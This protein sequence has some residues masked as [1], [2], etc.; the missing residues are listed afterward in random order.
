MSLWG[1]DSDRKRFATLSTTFSNTYQ[2]SSN[3]TTRSPPPLP[4][5]PPID[6]NIDTS[7]V[8]VNE[9]NHSGPRPC[10]NGRSYVFSFSLKSRIKYR[11]LA[12]GTRY[13]SLLLPK[14]VSNRS[15]P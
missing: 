6:C 14:T 8:S 2:Y 3:T 11:V 7:P 4:S 9:A 12:K 10:H 5:T 13:Y 1:M 15:R